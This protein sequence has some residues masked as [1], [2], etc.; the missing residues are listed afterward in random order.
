ML[1]IDLIELADLV[2]PEQLVDEILKQNPQLPLPVPVVELATLAGISK[3]EP[4]SSQGFEGTLIANAE[5][6]AGAIFYNGTV[7]R[8][9]QKFTIGHEFGHFLL[10]WHRQTTFECT[11]ED[12]SNRARKDWEIQANQFS[13]E[14]LMPKA[15]VK[16]RLHVMRDP[17]LAHIQELSN[18]FEVSFEAAARRLVELN[19]YACAVVFSKDNVVRYSVKSEYFGEQVAVR[20]GDKLPHKSPSKHAESDPEEWHEL[21]ASWWVKERNDDDMPES[22]YESGYK[23]TL[24]SL[25]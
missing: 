13:A 20:K 15:L 1:R 17:E 11:A 9:R 18:Q 19:E 12:I 3:I 8:P 4:L 24:L 23:V 22:I 5:K 25:S 2:R 14:L 6:S 10:P 7:P 21:I 16:S